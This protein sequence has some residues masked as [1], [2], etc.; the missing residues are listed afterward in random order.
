M[1]GE[2]VEI[3]IPAALDAGYRLF[4]TA[5]IYRNEEFV[6]ETLRK[7]MARRGIARSSVFITSKLQT[8][9]QGYEAATTAVNTS[10]A[11]LR[12]DYID[13]YLIHWP[14][15]SG[16]DPSDPL[17]KELRIGSWRALEEALAVG[18]LRSIG[19]SNYMLKHLEEMETYA[20]IMPMVNQIELHPAY[21]PE[22]VVGYCQSKQIVIQA[23]SSLGRG[24]LLEDSFLN[25]HP[26]VAKISEQHRVT[27]S[28]VYL[29][30]ALQHGWGIL[31]KSNSPHRI[32]ENANILHFKLSDKEMHY[33]DSIH[34]KET[35]KICWDPVTVM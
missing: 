8:K 15:A 30:W 32:K 1:T 34:I 5:T 12:V 35:Q 4:D 14:G 11:K 6:G 27:I 2:N 29:R 25:E 3:A 10:L 28:Q 31:P 13:L 7:E 17:N 24:K 20:N 9:D 18:K 26:Q 22:D 16:L 21:Y 33:L 23:Y 19:V